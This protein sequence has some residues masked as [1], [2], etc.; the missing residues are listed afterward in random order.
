MIGTLFSIVIALLLYL[1][2]LPEKLEVNYSLIGTI[3]FIVASLFVI[4]QTALTVYAWAPLQK[5]EQNLTPRVF[6]IFKKDRNL[7]ITNLFLLLFLLFTYLVVVDLFLFEFFGK[8]QMLILWTLMF[9]VAIDMLHHHLRRVMDFLDPYHVVE[10]LS[11]SALHC[12]KTSKEGELCDWIDTLT[13]TSIKGLEH[14]SFSL[15]ILA[16]DKLRLVTENYL[17][18][19]KRISY[20]EGESAGKFGGSDHISYMLFYLFQ[21]M[22]LIFDKA[23]EGRNEPACSNLI[24]TLGKIIIYCAKYDITL[25]GHPLYYCGRFVKKAQHREL[26]EVGNRGVVTLLEV[27]KVIIKD[28]DLQYV[29]IKDTFIDLVNTMHGIAKDT[30]RKDKSINI[31]LL[32]QPFSTLKEFFRNGK[33]ADHQD[34][35][36]IIASIDNVLVEFSSLE[37]VMRSMPPIP[38]MQK[39]AEEQEKSSEE[40]A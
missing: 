25:A 10:F 15:S 12:A 35:P 38:E 13:E 23:V 19:A 2:P 24:A 3:L 28:V 37:E 8:K 26:N 14:H 1:Y 18:I 4:N 27:A 20:H 22:E 39:E 17:E 36:S 21:R 40:P 9:G 30:F 34:T 16:V 32:M 33:I 7:R 5:M 29:E 11:N 6:A 31:P